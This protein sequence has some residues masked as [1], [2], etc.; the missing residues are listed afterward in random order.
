PAGACP[1]FVTSSRF[2]AP[3]NLMCGIV[4]YTGKRQAVEILIGGLR[5]LEYRGYDSAGVC[6]EKD[7]KLGLLRAKGRLSELE[8]ALR[9]D[10]RP[11]TTGIAHTRWATHGEPSERNA[12]PH[13][14]FDNQFAVV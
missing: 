2:S 7:G 14:S 9:K 8:S 3:E 4:A 1:G 11:G 12:H 6:V 13:L 5:K 10:P